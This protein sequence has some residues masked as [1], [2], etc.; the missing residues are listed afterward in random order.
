MCQGEQEMMKEEEKTMARVL[1]DRGEK[2]CVEHGGK[3][4]FGVDVNP[5]LCDHAPWFGRA[6]LPATQFESSRL[7]CNPRLE[8]VPRLE[9]RSAYWPAPLMEM[10]C[11]IS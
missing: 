1:I 10:P 8:F 11:G 2:T 9:M 4:S 7:L 5:G 6:A 3:A